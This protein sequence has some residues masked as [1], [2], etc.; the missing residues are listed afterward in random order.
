M[1]AMT[2]VKRDIKDGL[3]EMEGD[4][5]TA[6]GLIEAIFQLA[7]GLRPEDPDRAK[8]ISTIS[9]VL[10]A[11]IKAAEEKRMRLMRL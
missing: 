3:F 10:S 11:T 8:A 7:D 2:P 6:E 5:I 1:N 4:F 9:D